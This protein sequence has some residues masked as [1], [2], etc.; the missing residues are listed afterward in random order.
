MKR[1]R[2]EIRIEVER[3]LILRQCPYP[4]QY[5]CE[6]CAAQVEMLSPEDAALAS[7]RRP[8]AIY[9]LVEANRLHFRETPEGLLLVCLPSL[10][11]A[12]A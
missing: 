7:G 10:L 12:S 3:T 2:T 11:Q 6:L 5:W 9:R 8:R 4:T 1:R